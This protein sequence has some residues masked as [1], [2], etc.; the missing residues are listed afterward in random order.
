MKTFTLFPYRM[1]SFFILVSFLTI[2][3]CKKKATDPDYCATTWATQ[4]Q[5]QLNA[6]TNAAQVYAANPTVANCNAYKTATQNYL[7]ALTPFLDCAAWTVQ[8][9]NDL[10]SLIDSTQDQISSLCQ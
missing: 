6:V 8:Q 7:N 1:I 10:Q 4:V 3:S 9:K 2:G 5:T